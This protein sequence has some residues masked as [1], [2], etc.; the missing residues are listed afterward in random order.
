MATTLAQ[1]DVVCAGHICLDITPK[2]PD[3]GCRTVA[4]VF[5]P[6]KLVNV[7]EI[8]LHPGGP[9]AN[10][11]L[12]FAQMGVS[13]AF[14][15]KLGQDEFG[16]LTLERLAQAGE[17][18]GVRM[19][20]GEATAYSI[21]LAPPGIDR[22]FL[23]N[24]GPNDTF[25]SDDI[26]FSA[27]KPARLFHFGYPPIMKAVVENEGYELVKIFRLAKQCGVT[28]SLDMSLPD[29][30]SASGKLPWRKILERVLPYVDVFAPSIEEAT[31]C[32]EPDYFQKLHAARSGADFIETLPIEK[33]SDYGSLLL[34]MGCKIIVIKAA[35]R[36]IYLRT[37]ND[38]QLFGI[39]SALRGNF[40]GW[41]NRE[42]WCPT[43]NVLKIVNA[44]GA[45]DVAIAGFLTGMLRDFSVERALKTASCFGAQ[46]LSA[47]DAISGIQ[48]WDETQRQL[49]GNLLKLNEIEI[50]TPGW[51]WDKSQKLWF[52]PNDKMII[53]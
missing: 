27:V 31:F 37:T 15:A 36:G 34:E 17:V 24:P 30:H 49:E 13:T 10:T 26:D 29:P 48:S 6:G 43:F 47:A 45:G 11:G 19:M 18:S 20:N 16:K 12:A 41:A 3:V 52:G 46:N 7:E 21:V 35:Q 2:I 32:L 50:E 28:T 8:T 33:F 1:Y 5:R 14:V 39:G 42:I 44:T 25:V 22:I 51:Y 40:A 53:Q 4:E 9:V 23:H 38:S